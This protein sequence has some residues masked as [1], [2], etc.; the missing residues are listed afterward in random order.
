MAKQTAEQKAEMARLKLIPNDKMKVA[1]ASLNAFLATKEKEEMA[2]AS[3]KTIAVSLFEEAIA[4]LL[5]ADLG[6]EI[7][8]EVATF[9]NDHIVPAEEVEGE[10]DVT[11]NEVATEAKPDKPKPAK[12]PRK[13]KEEIQARYDAISAMIATAGHTKKEIV[14]TIS[15]KFPDVTVST[16]ST[17]V[18]DCMNVK[19]NKLPKLTIKGEDGKLSFAK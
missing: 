14:E 16:I 8:E 2:K 17:F 10:G 13:T 3:S 12:K 15:P 1:I 19:Y 4:G 9:Y 5:E 7:P 6:E 18:Q 11:G